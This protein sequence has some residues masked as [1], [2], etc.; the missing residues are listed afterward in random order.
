[1]DEGCHLCSNE[2]YVLEGEKRE[3]TFNPQTKG[4]C[5]RKHFRQERETERGRDEESER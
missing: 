5:L 3:L 4:S 1:M 2:E